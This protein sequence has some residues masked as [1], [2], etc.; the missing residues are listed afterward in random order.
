MT[1]GLS[2]P[3]PPPRDANDYCRR[4]CQEQQH[5]REMEKLDGDIGK[6]TI[7]ERIEVLMEICEVAI[8]HMEAIHQEIAD[9]GE[10]S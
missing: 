7:P 10:V 9:N 6:L 8:H 4:C 1:D 2:M 3:P 5:N